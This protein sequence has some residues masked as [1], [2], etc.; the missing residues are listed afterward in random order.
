MMNKSELIKKTAKETKCSEKQVGEIIDAFFK[1]L[2][3]TLREDDV[4][5]KDFGVFHKVVRPERM[6]RN[7][8][9]GEDVLVPKKEIVKFKPY[10][11]ILNM[12]W[13]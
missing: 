3:Q 13:L 1:E 6:A 9:T 2:S 8:A 7:P 12:K 4:Q 11:N 10:K 5:I